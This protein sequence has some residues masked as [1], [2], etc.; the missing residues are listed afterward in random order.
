[1]PKSLL[2]IHA[3]QPES[4]PLGDSINPLGQ[5]GLILIADE[6]VPPKHPTR[7]E[8]PSTGIMADGPEGVDDTPIELGG[9]FQMLLDRCKALEEVFIDVRPKPP[10]GT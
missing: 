10:I 5:L 8:P 7:I 9:S 4:D 2:C 1:M 6:I 3:V